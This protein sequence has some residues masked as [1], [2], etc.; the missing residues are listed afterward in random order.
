MSA[1][2]GVL[3]Q[4]ITNWRERLALTTATMRAMSLQTDPQELR[5]IYLDRMRIVRPLDGSVSLS[6]RGLK[7]PWVRITRSTRWAEDLNPWK[8][9]HRLPLLSGGLLA[10]LIY[11]DEPRLFD[12]LHISA[13]DP[14]AEYLAEFR[15]VAVIPLYD[16]GEALN[17]A[18][19]LRREPG[20]F[21]PEDLP[22]LVSMSNLFGRATHSLVVFG[23]TYSRL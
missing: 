3:K 13:D 20:A 17:M 15:S 6:R 2:V 19:L 12:D 9:P 8:E 11:G 1:P 14:A 7:A 4:K 5:R 10:E 21:D 16:Q 18:L 23:A 22:E